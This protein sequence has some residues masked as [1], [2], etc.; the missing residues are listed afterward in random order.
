MW[1]RPG[2]ATIVALRDAANPVQMSCPFVIERLVK[3]CVIYC[4]TYVRK[5]P[6]TKTDLPPIIRHHLAL[7]KTFA[8]KHGYQE[9]VE[10][11]V[12]WRTNRHRHFAD[13]PEFRKAV[14]TA[15]EAGG[16]VI[17]GHLAELLVATPP[18]MISGALN[19]IERA[20]GTVINATTGDVMTPSWKKAM[21]AAAIAA[22]NARR[23]PIVRG[24]K[25]SEP[26][27]PVRMSNQRNASLGAAQAAD[28]FA[29]LVKPEVD[30]V[31]AGL[32]PGVKL[33]PQILALALNERSVRA[34]RGGN[35]TVPSAGNLM[36]RL[37]KLYPTG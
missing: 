28:R 30:L 3:P 35:W 33:S 24:I 20:G 8:R 36:R 9:M 14:R 21:L 15:V 19:E 32:A 10:P 16:H 27:T 23:L 37:K 6:R 18:E 31:Q 1:C 22:A 25:L 5:S 2:S 11:F 7:A 4:F 17:V 12:A 26:R 29:R 13:V 34:S